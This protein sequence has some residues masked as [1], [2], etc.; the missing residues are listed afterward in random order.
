[1]TADPDDV[2]LHAV[3]HAAT[4]E[5]FDRWTDILV[6]LG[7]ASIGNRVEAHLLA[8]NDHAERRTTSSHTAA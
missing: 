8:L 7:R 2:E 4:F 3:I 1:M 6:N 5:H